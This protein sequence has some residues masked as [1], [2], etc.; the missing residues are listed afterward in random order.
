MKI[1]FFQSVDG[2]TIHKIDGNTVTTLD[3][4][5][6]KFMTMYRMYK[7]ECSISEIMLMQLD[8]VEST[9]D[10]FG[11]MVEEYL[12]FIDKSLTV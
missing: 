2:S 9:A 12:E 11:C 4:T 1:L 5:E 8:C 7:W 10:L 6:S 3:I